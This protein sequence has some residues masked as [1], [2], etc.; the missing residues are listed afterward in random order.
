MPRDIRLLIVARVAMSATRALAGII[1]PIYLAQV[2]FSATQLG[3]LFAVVA[4]TSAVLS[5]MVGLLADQLG[6]KPFVIALPLF[7]AVAGLVFAFSQLDA[8]LFIFAALGSFGRGAGAG[9]GSVGPYQPAEQAL[10]ADATPDRYRNS[11]FGR[12]AF[13]SSVGAI[14]GAPLAAIPQVAA[15]FGSHGIAGYRPA[16]L[17]TALLAL[18]AALIVIPIANPRTSA[19]TG[20]NPFQFPRRSWPLLFKLWTT[21]SVNGLAVG[22][23]GPFVT[24]WFYRR[25]GATAGSIGLLYTMINVATLVSTLGAANIARQLGLVRAIVV[26]RIVSAMLLVAMVQA[27]AF[28]LAGAIYLV[29]MLAQRVSLP[30][31][32]SYVMAMAP[33]E[34]R[35]GVAA[36]SN[37][38]SQVASAATPVAAGYLFEQVSLALPFEVGAALQTIN[39]ILYYLFFHDLHPPEEAMAPVVQ[40]G[41]AEPAAGGAGR[42]T[43]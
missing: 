22:F 13:A 6:R 9:A 39:G 34:E 42:G 10:I 23:F 14:I 28:W 41:P 12:L 25:Y 4:I 26:S 17:V 1:T 24:Y 16:F 11:V 19:R 35:A 27:P 40:S 5:A 43:A 8:L 32:Q 2:G 20:R 30:L 7:A 15:S 37:I 29:R 36:L 31:R 3:E 21:N 33:P 18:L 38:P